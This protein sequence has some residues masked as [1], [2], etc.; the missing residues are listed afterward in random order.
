MKDIKE[1]SYLE[2]L[3]SAAHLAMKIENAKLDLNYQQRKY[4]EYLEAIGKKIKESGGK[5]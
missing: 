5:L 1:M 2:L 4:R 3:E